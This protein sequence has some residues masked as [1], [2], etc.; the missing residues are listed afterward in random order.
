M[1]QTA[2]PASSGPRLK[3]RPF[4]WVAFFRGPKWVQYVAEGKPLDQLRAE[5]VEQH[6]RYD[7][8]TQEG[9]RRSA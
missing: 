6:G 5:K 8:A 2:K 7:P 9:E 4:I 1:P 3:G